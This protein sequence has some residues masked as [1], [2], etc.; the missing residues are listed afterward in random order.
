M[1]K[2]PFD[3]LIQANRMKTYMALGVYLIIFMCI[4]FLADIIR[5]NLPSL[6][7]GIIM[8]LTL[9]EFPLITMIMGIVSLG[10]I[11]FSVANASRI[12]LSG[13]VYKLIDPNA[14]LSHKESNAYRALQE[15]VQS[16]GLDFIPKLYVFEAPYMN[17]FASGWNAKNSMIA[18]TSTLLEHLDAQELKAVIAHEL[19]HIRHGDVRLTMCVGILSN[20]MLLAVNLFA[21]SSSANSQG[22]KNARTILLILQF[23]LPLFTAVLSLFISRSREYMADSGAAYLMNDSTPMIKALQKISQDYEQNSYQESNPTRA[24]AYLFDKS[25]ILSTHPSI[26]NRIKA[27]LEQ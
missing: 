14:P 16:A 24:N 7:E 27:L 22:A 6:D 23:V 15:L 8:L 12:M 10:V 25:E 19:S 3:K 26:Q 17:A 20:I 9:Q 2:S 4:G 1:T 18:I 13:N 11:L 21:F 5:L